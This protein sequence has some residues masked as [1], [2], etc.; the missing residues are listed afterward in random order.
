MQTEQSGTAAA[1]FSDYSVIRAVCPE[2]AADLPQ[3][4]SHSQ[5]KPLPKV[6]CFLLILTI[7]SLQYLIF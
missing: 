6:F 5:L 2:A 3:S 7:E 4:I 1:A